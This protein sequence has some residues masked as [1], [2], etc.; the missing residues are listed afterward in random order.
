MLDKEDAVTLDQ[1]N[2]AAKKLLVR[3]Q[4]AVVI[5]LPAS[6]DPSGSKKVAQ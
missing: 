3:D 1:V 2:A 4:R 6:Q 5:T